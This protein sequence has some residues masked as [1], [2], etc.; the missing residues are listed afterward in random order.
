MLAQ[1][2]C[3]SEGVFARETTITTCGPSRNLDIIE[4]YSVPV[5]GCENYELLLKLK[6]TLEI[7]LVV[8]Q[9]VVDKAQGTLGRMPP[10][11]EL[12]TQA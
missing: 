5:Q 2:L 9:N 10:F 8:P 11:I 1:Y 6:D 3:F 7:T 4:T 12:R